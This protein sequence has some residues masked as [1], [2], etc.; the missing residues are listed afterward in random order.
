MG[1]SVVRLGE[2]AVLADLSFGKSAKGR[3]FRR[4]FQH[5]PFDHIPGKIQD[6]F[7]VFLQ[8]RIFRLT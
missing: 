3:F 1:L 7:Y 5:I 8:S 6:L 4:H 2:M